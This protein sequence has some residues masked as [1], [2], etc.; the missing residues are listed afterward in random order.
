MLPKIN[1]IGVCK[2]S[3]QELNISILML[4][5]LDGK[6]KQLHKSE[7]KRDDYVKEPF[8]MPILLQKV[9]VIFRCIGKGSAY[10]IRWLALN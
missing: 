4:N 2:L 1:R 6:Q 9:W 5:T 3:R 10:G 8:S 7:M